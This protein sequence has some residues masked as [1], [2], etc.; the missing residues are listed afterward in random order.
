[1]LRYTW[2]WWVLLLTR[3]ERWGAVDS[4]HYLSHYHPLPFYYHLS[5]HKSYWVF[6]KKKFYKIFVCLFLPSSQGYGRW[7][8]YRNSIFMINLCIDIWSC[9]YLYSYVNDI[10]S[11]FFLSSIEIWCFYV[12]NEING[13]GTDRPIKR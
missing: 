8:Y 3:S 1:M 10:K 11:L 6:S 5:G 13:W 4:A 9:L 12:R 2:A 7:H